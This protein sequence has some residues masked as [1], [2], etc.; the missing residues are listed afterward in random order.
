MTPLRSRDEAALQGSL[1]SLRVNGD[2]GGDTDQ[3]E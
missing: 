3:D 1:S 2:G